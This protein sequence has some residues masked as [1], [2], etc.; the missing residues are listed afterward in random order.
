M[1]QIPTKEEIFTRL[2]S[3]YLTIAGPMN[4]DEGSIPYGVYVLLD[5]LNIR[6][7]RLEAYLDIDSRGVSG[8]QARFADTYDGRPIQCCRSMRPKPTHW[9]GRC[10][11]NLMVSIIQVVQ[12]L[13]FFNGGYGNE[14]KQRHR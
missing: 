14:N 12:Y 6:I 1:I 2:V 10:E 5:G 11:C 4:V 9:R 13:A 8:A 7:T 3:R